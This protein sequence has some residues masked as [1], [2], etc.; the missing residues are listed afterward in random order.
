MAY[1]PQYGP[2]TSVVAQNRRNQMNATYELSKLRSGTD[3][4]VGLV[5]GH[6]APGAANPH[7]AHA[8][9]REQ[10]DSSPLCAN[11]TTHSLF[12]TATK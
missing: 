11:W 12:P 4:D 3:E 8:P 5:L 9:C 1:T 10:D 6:L 7:R 2:G